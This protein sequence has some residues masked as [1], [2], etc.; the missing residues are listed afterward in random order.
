MAEYKKRDVVWQ[1]IFGPGEIKPGQGFIIVDANHE[2]NTYKI[3]GLED[4]V[5]RLE[6]RQDLDSHFSKQR[7]NF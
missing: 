4:N 7:A 1:S 5:I 6:T 3:R 2:T